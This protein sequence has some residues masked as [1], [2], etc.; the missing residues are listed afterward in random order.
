MAEYSFKCPECENEQTVT[1]VMADYDKPLKCEK[2]G[3]KMA[4]LLSVSG[5]SRCG[6]GYPM[7]SYAVGVGASEVPAA[8]EVDKKGGVPTRYTKD[9]DPEF[10]SRGH[11]KKYLKLHGFHDRNSYNGD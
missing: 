6:N 11:R 7:A 3:T 4:R 5:K 1:R 2:C 8:M 10:T 9:G